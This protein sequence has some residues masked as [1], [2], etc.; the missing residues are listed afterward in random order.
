MEEALQEQPDS[1]TSNPAVAKTKGQSQGKGK[2]KGKGAKAKDGAKAE[3][4]AKALPARFGVKRKEDRK[5]A[6]GKLVAVLAVAL[7]AWAVLQ[8]VPMM[9]R[10]EIPEVTIADFSGMNGVTKIMARPPSVYV[11][12][13]SY[14]WGQMAHKDRV[15]L[16][17]SIGHKIEGMGYVGA[18]IMGD[19]GKTVAQWLQ[20]TGTTVHDLPTKAAP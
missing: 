13:D 20:K 2:S 4:K 1:R 18:H 11:E 14:A 8:G 3:Q 12:V 16:V 15:S 10:V 17:E 7:I 6:A 19:N 9:N 5:S